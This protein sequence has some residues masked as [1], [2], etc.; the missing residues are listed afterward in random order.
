MAK[1]RTEKKEIVVSLDVGTSKICAV[2]AEVLPDNQLEI[3]GYGVA[4]SR[5]LKQ[6]V[7]VNI[8]ATVEC[9]QQA[10]EEAEDRDFDLTEIQS[11]LA[12][13]RSQKTWF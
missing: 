3:L 13:Y 2:V 1:K 10:L 8:E 6:G 11:R 7:V 4:A 5:G 12:A 9:I